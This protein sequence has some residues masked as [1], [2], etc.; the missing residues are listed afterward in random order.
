M[1]KRKIIQSLLFIVYTTV[2][3]YLTLLDRTPKTNRIFRPDLFYEIRLF[4]TG[5]ASGVH[6]LTLF[7]ENIL[8]YVPYG[9]LLPVKKNRKQVLSVILLTS[10]FIELT[11]YV[12]ILGECEIDDMIANTIGGMIGF[13]I[14]KLINKIVTT[15]NIIK[16]RDMR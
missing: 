1:N 14:Y 3:L 16:E 11:Q 6:Y 2:I 5:D 15:K 10:V 13:G 7:I 9:F 4:V 8:F 12:L